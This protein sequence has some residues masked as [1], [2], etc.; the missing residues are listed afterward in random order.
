MRKLI[1]LIRRNRLANGFYQVDL[2]YILGFQAAERKFFIRTI[3]SPDTG[4]DITKVSSL[5]PLPDN[6]KRLRETLSGN[7]RRKLHKAEKYGLEIKVGETGLL[8]AFFTNYVQKMHLLGSPAYG[9]KFFK[10][11]ME[12]WQFGET[13][14][15]LVLKEKKV[16]G[17]AFLQSYLG[18]YENTWFATDQEFFKYYVSDYLHDQMIKYAVVNGGKYYS[19]GRSTIGSGVYHYKNHWPVEDLPIYQFGE[20]SRLK[21]HPEFGNLWKII[22][23]FII[24]PLGSYLI[25]HIY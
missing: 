5:M 3:H 16:I 12:S 19:F 17:T 8:D 15:F 11:L 9:K 4:A 10:T 1:S 13:K 25:K 24:Q 2:Q 20:N 18:F 7:L 6:T 23:R 21:K 14:I 22:P